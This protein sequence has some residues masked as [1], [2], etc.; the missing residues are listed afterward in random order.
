MK[1]LQAD[2]DGLCAS[3]FGVGAFCDPL[4][5]DFAKPKFETVF[6]IEITSSRTGLL[7]R[8]MRLGVIFG[9]R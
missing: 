4:F 5:R 9:L 1:I 7:L 6:C 8:I 2:E 3:F